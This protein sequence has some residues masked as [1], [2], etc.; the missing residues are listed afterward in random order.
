METVFGSIWDP[1]GM[2][3]CFLHVPKKNGVFSTLDSEL[4]FRRSIFVRCL[5]NCSRRLVSFFGRTRL[6]TWEPNSSTVVGPRLKV[7][8][9]FRSSRNNETLAEKSL[10]R[11]PAANLR[12]G[13]TGRPIAGQ[14]QRQMR[15]T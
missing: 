1:S 7:V 6:G 11:F 3:Y 13:G 5:R 4:C 15:G 10:D 9:F 2:V 8:A 12:C 14:A